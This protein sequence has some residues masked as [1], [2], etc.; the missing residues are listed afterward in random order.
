MDPE[1]AAMLVESV[2]IQAQTIHQMISAHQ[3]QQRKLENSFQSERRS[4]R[5]ERRYFDTS[6]RSARTNRRSS[7]SDRSSFS[8]RR[9][10]NRQFS[11]SDRSFTESRTSYSSRRREPQDQSNTDEKLITKIQALRQF[12]EGMRA[13]PDNTIGPPIHSSTPNPTHTH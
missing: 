12:V 8:D 13:N 2:H 6:N 7:K 10:S 9:S 3:N 4:F 1:T 5:S 11:C